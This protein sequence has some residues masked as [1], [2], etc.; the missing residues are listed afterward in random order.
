[1]LDIENLKHTIGVLSLKL[2]ADGTIALTKAGIKANSELEKL[3]GNLTALNVINN[4]NID[5]L[6]N[7]LSFQDK[8]NL[9]LNESSKVLEKLQRLNQQ[10]PHSLKDTTKIYQEV[11]SSMK[12][13]QVSNEDMMDITK[14]LSIATGSLG[15]EFNDVVSQIGNMTSGTVDAS[16]QM[17]NF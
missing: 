5:S 2:F 13:M 12:D 14:K 11:Y 1:M 17:V 8:Y 3:N 4:K 15:L 9:A 6:G 10:T 7:S 16:S